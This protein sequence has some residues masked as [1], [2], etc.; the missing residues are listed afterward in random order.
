MA[1]GRGL[2]AALLALAAVPKSKPPEA[3]SLQVADESEL[4]AALAA[5]RDLDMAFAG[6]THGWLA[7]EPAPSG[8]LFEYLLQRVEV[9]AP[10]GK[11]VLSIAIELAAQLASQLPNRRN[12]R[13]ACVQ[14]GPGKPEL[15]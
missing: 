4:P 12:V 7:F 8:P 2:D 15:E 1:P 10:F 14:P 9:S 13:G 6:G 3:W 11:Q 5:L